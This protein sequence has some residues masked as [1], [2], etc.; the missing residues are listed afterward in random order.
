MKRGETGEKLAESK[1]KDV[2]CFQAILP[3]A[4]IYPPPYCFSLLHVHTLRFYQVHLRDVPGSSCSLESASLLSWPWIV[5]IFCNSSSTGAGKE[6]GE[7]SVHW[8]SGR[9]AG[10]V[11]APDWTRRDAPP[12]H[13]A[14]HSSQQPF[15]GRVQD[16]I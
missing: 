7:A 4:S 6:A 9:W 13:H 2:I 8:D 10:R 3:R 15:I 11:A 1:E 14:P 16:A 12:S 5:H